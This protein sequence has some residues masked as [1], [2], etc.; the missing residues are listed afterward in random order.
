MADSLRP[1][2]LQPTRLVRPWDFPGKSTGVGFHCL[3]LDQ[4]SV[5]G[6]GRSPGESSGYL[7][8]YSCLENSVDRGAWLPMNS[9]LGHKNSDMTEQLTHK[10][11]G[12]FCCCCFVSS[13][14]NSLGVSTQSIILST[15]RSESESCIRLSATPW[16]ITVL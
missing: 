10:T 7:L 8:Q 5:P 11:M 2:G 14:V 16:T 3:L 6:I 4:G 12:V 9:P 1:H 13:L 15:N